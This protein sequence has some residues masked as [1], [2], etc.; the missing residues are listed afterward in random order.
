[1]AFEVIISGNALSGAGRD[2]LRFTQLHPII[3][4]QIDQAHFGADIEAF[5]RR[6]VDEPDV[7]PPEFW[8]L[9]LQSNRTALGGECR[10]RCVGMTWR[11]RT[12]AGTMR[13]WRPRME[14][15]DIEERQHGVEVSGWVEQVAI[16][17]RI[18]HEAGTWIIQTGASNAF[19]SVLWK[20]MLEQIA[21]CTP[22]LTGFVSRVL[23]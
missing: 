7:L 4:T 23:W 6:M 10:P 3:R 20:P 13:E 17:A 2:G 1:M 12:A 9:F 22:A 18:H 14:K 19:D 11:R 21:A 5:W 8:G 15:L 16:R